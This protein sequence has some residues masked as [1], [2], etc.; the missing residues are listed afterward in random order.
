VVAWVQ[1]R[2]A[3]ASRRRGRF[4]RRGGGEDRPTS[5]RQRRIRRNVVPRGARPLTGTH[6][7]PHESGSLPVSDYD[8]DLPEGLVAADPARPARCLAAARAGPRLGGHRSPPLPRLARPPRERDVV[9]L[10][11]TRVVPARLL[12]RKQG[13]G[14]RVELLLV[15]PDADVDAS[16]ALSGAADALSWVCLGQA[17][18]GVRPGT[19][20]EL[21]GG[22]A[23]VLERSGR[24]APGPLRGAGLGGRA[25][26]AHRAG[27]ASPLRLPRAHGRGPDPLPDRLRAGGRLGRRSHRR[28]P[29]HPQDPR[30]AGGPR[31]RA[32][33]RHPRCRSRDLP[34]GARRGRVHPPDARRALPGPGRDRGG[35]EPRPRRGASHRCGRDD[36][37]ADP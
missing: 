11:D 7:V 4:A 9:V 28:A 23:T 35:G 6:G 22:R 20:V 2:P 24:G 15:R 30:R 13:S 27:A 19:V 16:A 1:A 36:G 14:G 10:N 32:S 25:A 26:R 12:G 18:K 29:P 34:P 21:D 5:A 3:K 31:G 17:S 8:F 33:L 37:G